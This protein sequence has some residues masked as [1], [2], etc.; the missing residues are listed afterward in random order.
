MRVYLLFDDT[1][2]NY[3]V[4]R[5]TEDEL[6]PATIEGLEVGQSRMLS[7]TMGIVREV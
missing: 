1:S 2:V 3:Y 7:D 6:K 5:R 4:G